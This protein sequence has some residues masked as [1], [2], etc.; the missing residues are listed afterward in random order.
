LIPA[1]AAFPDSGVSWRVLTSAAG[2]WRRPCH[3]RRS[4]RDR[5]TDLRRVVFV[6]CGIKEGFS[7]INMKGKYM[8]KIVATFLLT[9]LI[10]SAVMA[11]AKLSSGKYV[12]SLA[13]A[14]AP[15]TAK[16]H[17]KHRKHRKPA[18]KAPAKH[19]K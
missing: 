15:T 13:A 14:A 3:S 19:K 16:K 11:E 18:P 1:K 17:A 7:S 5:S 8:K 12:H 9:G 6:V 4:W 10:A 2:V